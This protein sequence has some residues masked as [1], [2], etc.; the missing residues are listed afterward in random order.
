MIVGGTSGIGGAVAEQYLKRGVDVTVIGRNAPKRLPGA[1]FVQADLSSMATA[2]RVALKLNEEKK[3]F[4]VVLLTLGVTVFDGNI[5]RT[6]EGIERKLAIS[7]F[8]RYVVLKYLALQK[9]TRVFNL[10]YPGLFLSPVSIPDINYEKSTELY[11]D[12]RSHMNT[13]IFNEAIVLH[14]AKKNL[15]YFGIAPGWV[16]SDGF[17]AAFNMPWAEPLLHV[18][19]PT[20]EEFAQQVL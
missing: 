6:S 14:F 3:Q 18:F 13:H 12:I 8:S 5:T 4:D 11:S 10:A 9:N 7:Y 20:A 19:F 17:R 1:T 2:K 15:Q 16:L